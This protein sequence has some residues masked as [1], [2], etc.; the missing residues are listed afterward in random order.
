MKVFYRT[1]FAVYSATKKAKSSI[2]YVSRRT[3]WGQYLMVMIKERKNSFLE[4]SEFLMFFYQNAF[5][6]MELIAKMHGIIPNFRIF[7]TITYFR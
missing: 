2:L 5:F 4:F 1:E 6:L 7:R 3:M